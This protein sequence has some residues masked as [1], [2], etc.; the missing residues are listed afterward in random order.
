MQEYAAASEILKTA[1]GLKRSPIAITLLS[2]RPP[3]EKLVER[4]RFCEMWSRAMG[5]E[6][7]YAT[8]KEEGCG[9]GAYY[10]GLAEA[11]PEVRSGALLSRIYPLY[12]TTMAAVR[13]NRRSPRIPCGTGVAVMCAPL[14]AAEGDVH[15]ALIVCEPAGAMKLVDAACHESGGYVSGM[16]GPATCSV[17]VA[18]PYLSG[19]INYCVADVGARDYMKLAPEEMIVSI[20]G[21]RVLEAARNLK[22]TTGSDLYSRL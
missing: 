3:E 15:V 6:T 18:Y 22:R 16:T 5:G 20:P 14:E 1:L 17:A 12:R 11:A 19:Q 9:G 2:E 13:T 4:I 10:M 7:I 21:D 8:E